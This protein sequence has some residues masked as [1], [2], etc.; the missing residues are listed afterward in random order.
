MFTRAA[1]VQ[2]MVTPNQPRLQHTPPHPGI[3]QTHLHSVASPLP[4]L[5]PVLVFLPLLA[6]LL[7]LP[8]LVEPPLAQL[9]P[10]LRTGASAGPLLVIAAMVGAT[11]GRTGSRPRLPPL[12]G[13]L[14]LLPPLELTGPP[15]HSLSVAQ[16]FLRVSGCNLFCH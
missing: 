14:P 10:Q 4:L 3:R 6:P 12:P 13:P 15:L 5:E 11:Q 1:A 2:A 7:S 9:L 16:T 8:H